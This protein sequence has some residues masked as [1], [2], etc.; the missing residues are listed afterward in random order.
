MVFRSMVACLVVSQGPTSLIG[1]CCFI[2]LHLDSDVDLLHF[3]TDPDTRIRASDQWIRILIMLFLALT[4][5]DD[6]K[7]YLLTNFLLITF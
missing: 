6:N 4:F 5:Q 7:N 2:V 1:L 3:G